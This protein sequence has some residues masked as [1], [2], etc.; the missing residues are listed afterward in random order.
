MDSL[1]A[2]CLIFSLTQKEQTPPDL[3]RHDRSG[4]LS[5]AYSGGEMNFTWKAEDVADLARRWQDSEASEVP[6]P[7]CAFVDAHQRVDALVTESG[8]GLPD[9]VIHDLVRLELRVVWEEQQVVVVIDE[10]GQLAEA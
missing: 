7:L 3:W 10:I 2:Q 1:D 4:A 9:V 6:E 5:C 8:L